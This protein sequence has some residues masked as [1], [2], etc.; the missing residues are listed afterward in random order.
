MSGDKTLRADPADRLLGA[1]AAGDARIDRSGDKPVLVVVT[2]AGLRRSG[3]DEALLGALVRADLVRLDGERLTPTAAG[4][5]RLA[6]NRRPH[7]GFRAQHG[8]VVAV[9]PDAV[10]R[11]AEEVDASRVPGDAE[12]LGARASGLGAG[13]RSRVAARQR[14]AEDP[15]RAMSATIAHIDLA[16]SPL[17]WLARRGHLAA[18]EIQAGER[19]RGDFTRA[20]MMPTV[21]S[22]WSD[23]RVAGGKGGAGGS[24]I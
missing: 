22:N 5:A 21:T 8:D 7:L 3:L 16:E 17:G 24:P 4:R 13:R 11:A 9:G 12:A 19:L 20:R 18:A 10:D 15:A 1:I 2:A 23:G 14:R 6:R